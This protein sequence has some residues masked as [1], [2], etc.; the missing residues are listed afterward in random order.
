MEHFRQTIAIMAAHDSRW[1]PRDAHGRRRQLTADQL[2][3][4]ADL[5]SNLPDRKGFIGA[6]ANAARTLRQSARRLPSGNHGGD[7][8]VQPSTPGAA[9]A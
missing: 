2:N 6:W 4:L 3:A 7:R 5:G 8:S 1:G 9:S